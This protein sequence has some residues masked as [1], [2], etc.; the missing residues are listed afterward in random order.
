[1]NDR[2]SWSRAVAMAR[3]ETYHVLRDPYT[4]ALALG[5]PILMVVIYG[6]AIEFNVKEGYEQAARAARRRSRPD[7]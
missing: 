7:A 6:L 1:M 2:F 3:K 4:L 5:M